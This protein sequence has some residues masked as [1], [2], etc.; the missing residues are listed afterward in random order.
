VSEE[1]LHSFLVGEIVFTFRL[2]AFTSQV[3]RVPVDLN[4]FGFLNNNA[5]VVKGESVYIIMNV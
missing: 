1:G 2:V 3:N 4:K 5:P